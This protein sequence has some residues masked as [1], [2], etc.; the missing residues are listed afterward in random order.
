MA[1]L[2]R[3]ARR[4]NAT[5]CLS[6]RITHK[7]VLHTVSRRASSRRE[8]PSV[9]PLSIFVHITVVVGPN[10]SGKTSVGPV[11]DL[12]IT[13]HEV[14][15]GGSGSECGAGSIAGD[16]PWE[17]TNTWVCPKPSLYEPPAL[18]LL[19][20]AQA[21]ELIAALPP[22]FRAAVPGTSSAVPH[23]PPVSVTTNAW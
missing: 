9:R 10:G 19:A 13:D 14:P 7:H 1:T 18:Q 2:R 12:T 21:I 22:L 16:Q 15:T 11:R 17:T 20:E 5:P 8:S 6:D 3:Y 23:F 4:R